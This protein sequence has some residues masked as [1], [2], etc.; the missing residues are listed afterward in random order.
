MYGF[1][2]YEYILV[3]FAIVAIQQLVLIGVHTDPRT[4][5]EEMEALVDVYSAVERLWRTDDI[6]I[7][8]DLNADCSYASGRDREGLTLRTNSQFSWL[9]DDDVD[10][11]TTNSDCA[12]DRCVCSLITYI[13]FTDVLTI[14]TILLSKVI[15]SSFLKYKTSVI[16]LII[17][18][19]LRQGIR[20]LMFW[21]LV[22][23]SQTLLDSHSIIPETMT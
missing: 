12:Y 20:M 14:I 2:L 6:L 17:D 16:I 8:G 15:V 7:L 10:T 19:E 11:T 5:V 13:C 23:N 22:S 3:M 18:Y 4:A 1:E 9:I 21:F